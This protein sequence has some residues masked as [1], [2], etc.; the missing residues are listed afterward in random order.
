MPLGASLKDSRRG[1]VA[2]TDGTAGQAVSLLLVRRALKAG[3][4]SPPL[5]AT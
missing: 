2:I 3:R 4:R 1:F 5:R